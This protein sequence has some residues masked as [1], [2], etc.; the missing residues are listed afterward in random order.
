MLEEALEV[1][2]ALWS[3]EVVD[4]HGGYYTVEN[5]RLFDVPDEPIQVMVSAFGKKSAEVAGKR[6]DG[7]WMTG[8]QKEVLD[9]YIAAGGEG[10]KIGQLTICWAEDADQAVATAHRIWPNSAIPGQLSQDLPTPAH[11]E[12]AATLVRAEDVFS[13]IVC[14]PD[15]GPVLEAI[16]SYENDGLDHIHLHQIGPDQSGF[17]S[18]WEKQLAPKL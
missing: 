5:A 6:G 16:R 2:R 1:M 14:G 8:P 7:L 17:F 11:F 4:F 9:A 12:Q 10:W 15:P 13:K 3:G 18:F